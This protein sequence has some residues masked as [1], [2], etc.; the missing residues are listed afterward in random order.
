MFLLKQTKWD[1]RS[2]MARDRKREEF[3]MQTHKPAKEHEKWG[4]CYVAS[5][6]CSSSAQAP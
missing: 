1:N 3:L 6:I 2:V 5:L 4:H